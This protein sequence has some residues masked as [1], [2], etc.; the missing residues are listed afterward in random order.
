MLLLNILARRGIVI[1]RL[2]GS[3]RMS[4]F[5]FPY[6]HLFCNAFHRYEAKAVFEVSSLYCKMLKLHWERSNLS[7]IQSFLNEL[8]EGKMYYIQILF[9]LCGVYQW[10]TTFLVFF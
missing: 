8:Q 4:S 6:F 2:N 1:R 3:F 10:A 9:M 7:E 5:L